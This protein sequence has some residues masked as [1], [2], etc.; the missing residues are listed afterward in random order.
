ME[1]DARGN[2]QKLSETT[3]MT[4]GRLDTKGGALH[5]RLRWTRLDEI[6]RLAVRLFSF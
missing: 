4:K 2:S 1:P 3:P 6:L 5:Q